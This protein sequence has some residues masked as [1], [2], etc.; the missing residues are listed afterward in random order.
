MDVNLVLSGSGTRFPIFAGAL[1]ALEEKGINVQKTAGSSGGGLVAACISIAKLK[2]DDLFNSIL[3]T[4]F[5]SF[6]DFSLITLVRNYGLYK[7]DAV[8]KLAEK[9]TGGITFRYVPSDCRIIASSPM[10]SKPVIF[11]KDTTPDVKVSAA[12]RYSIS[13]PLVFGYKKYNGKPLVDG[14]LTSN[15]PIDIFNGD[16][17]KT[18]GLR[19]MSSDRQTCCFNKLAIWDY[20]GYLIESLILSIEQEHMEDAT[21]AFTIEFDATGINPLNFNVTDIDKHKMFEIGYD[22]AK[23]ALGEWNG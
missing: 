6:K 21:N 16:V 3:Q 5:N 2:A 22:T 14:S 12:I 13:V 19:I 10:D 8:E 18:I 11:S 9:I 17:N 23:K 20:V 4:D 7:G 15:Y 1:K